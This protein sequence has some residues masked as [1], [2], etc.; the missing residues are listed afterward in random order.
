MDKFLSRRQIIWAR[1]FTSTLNWTR[2]KMGA[3]NHT[4]RLIKAELDILLFALYYIN[5]T[6]NL[7][8]QWPKVFVVNYEF[9]FNA[10]N[11]YIQT[12]KQKCTMRYYKKNLTNFYKMFY[13]L[14]LFQLLIILLKATK[15]WTDF[16]WCSRKSRIS[17]PELLRL[18]VP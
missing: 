8:F 3:Q 16:T 15:F 10:K 5:N 7:R 17:R 4:A 18:L 14:M 1:N 6:Y 12:N 2:K 13:R 9:C 11:K